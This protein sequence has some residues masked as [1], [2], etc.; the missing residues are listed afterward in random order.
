MYNYLVTLPQSGTV[1]NL[2]L[3]TDLDLSIAILTLFGESQVSF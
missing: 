2:P 3:I 1:E